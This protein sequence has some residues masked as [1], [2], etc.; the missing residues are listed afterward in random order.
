MRFL[1][2]DRDEN[3][4]GT[5]KDVTYARHLEEIN[6]EDTLTLE[7]LET[8]QVEKNGLFTGTERGTER[9]SSLRR[10]TRHT[11]IT[12]SGTR[13]TVS[14]PSTRLWATTSTTDGPTT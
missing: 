14:R 12:A 10:S 9:N 11:A 2:F 6:G 13:S 1:L 5:V 8:T 3:Y 7:T 4:I